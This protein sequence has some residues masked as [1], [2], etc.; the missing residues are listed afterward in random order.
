MCCAAARHVFSSIWD[1]RQIKVFRLTFTWEAGKFVS[2]SKLHFLQHEFEAGHCLQRVGVILS[3]E[4]ENQTTKRLLGGVSIGMKTAI[5]ALQ[6]S[7][8]SVCSRQS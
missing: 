8:A 1:S 7:A 2:D 3:G 5:Y 4:K 6:F